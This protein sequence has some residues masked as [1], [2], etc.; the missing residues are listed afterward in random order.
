[1]DRESL[2]SGLLALLEENRGE[3]YERFDEG[4][5]LRTDLGLDSVDLVSLVLEVQDKFRIHLSI[6]DLEQVV[7]VGQLLDLLMQKL[8]GETRSAA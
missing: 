2:K 6:T 5:N 3:K 4:Q 7:T 8:N 1:M